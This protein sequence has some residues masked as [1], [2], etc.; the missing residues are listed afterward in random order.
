M[1][2]RTPPGRRQLPGPQQPSMEGRAIARPNWRTGCRPRCA[3]P[4]FNGGPG[5][6]PAEL[7]LAAGANV[8]VDNLQWRAG[9][10]PGRT[11]AKTLIGETCAQP[12]MEGRAI[13]RPNRQSSRV[14][15]LRDSPSMEGRAI[16]RPNPSRRGQ[17]CCLRRPS[18]EGRAIAR[19]NPG[20]AAQARRPPRPSMEGRAIARP[21]W[22]M[23]TLPSG[24]AACLQWRAGQLPGRTCR[25]DPTSAAPVSSFNGGPGNCPAEPGTTSRSAHRP[26]PFNGGP[27]NC[28]AERLVW[29]RRGSAALLLQWRA[30]QL[31]GRTGGG[32]GWSPPRPRSLQWRAGQLP[33]RTFVI[34]AGFVAEVQPSM[35][36]RAIA[37]PNSDGGL[38]PVAAFQALQWRAGQL[39]GRTT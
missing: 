8:Y 15:R 11:S 26:A 30:G 25:A 9:Q 31:P 19:P 18:M 21:N 7:R 12:S 23:V 2:G 1:P 4:S 33:G 36:G 39:P 13:A 22:V 5:N 38:L 14:L 27:G 29:L 37:R 35:E 20:R 6:C 28:P 10:L 34:P 16:A 32:P 3:G 24:C 17:S